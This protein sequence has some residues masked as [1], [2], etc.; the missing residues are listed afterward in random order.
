MQ[1]LDGVSPL[2]LASQEGHL[3]VVRLLIRA[4]AELDHAIGGYTALYLATQQGHTKVVKELLKA[5]ASPNTRIQ[6]NGLTPLHSACFQ[7]GLSE[8]ET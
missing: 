4:G 5:G 7:V 6:A 1:R 3:G 2:L 8:V